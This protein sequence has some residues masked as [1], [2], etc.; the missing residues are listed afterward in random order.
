MT[1]EAL[2][3]AAATLV[4]TPFRL[5]GRDPHFG[6]DCIGLLQAALERAGS[7]IRLPNGYPLRM[8]NPQNWVPD[9]EPCG[10]ASATPPF[11]AGDVI[12]VCLGQGQVHLAIADMTGNWIHAHAGLRRV[13][14]SPIPPPGATLRHWRPTTTDGE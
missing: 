5:H 4:G 9:P 6:L 8:R 11:L 7:T 10:F 1:G 12:L 13:V 14:V 3:K 2:A